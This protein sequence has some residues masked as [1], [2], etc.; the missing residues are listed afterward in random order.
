MEGSLTS[1]ELYGIIPRSAQAMFDHL[2]QPQFKEQVVT[3]SY[4]ESYNEEL[5]DLLMDSNGGVK[6][7][8]MEG[9]DGTFCR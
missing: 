1:P 8:I 3:C 6:M 2:K 7:D 5:R 9:K 4:L